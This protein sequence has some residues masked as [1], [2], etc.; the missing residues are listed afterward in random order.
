MVTLFQY[1]CLGIHGQKSLAGYSPRGCKES[2]TT[3]TWTFTFMS[4]GGLPPQI[5]AQ[6]LG[7]LAQVIPYFSKQ[8]DQT[9][10]GGPPHL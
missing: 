9:A 3:N 10:K 1:S 7:P 6:K 8:S 4:E 2:D 5:L